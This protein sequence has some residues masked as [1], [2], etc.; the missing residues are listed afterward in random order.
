MI[1]RGRRGLN[2]KLGVREGGA[3]KRLE[4]FDTEQGRNRSSS[5]NLIEM[6]LV[7]KKQTGQNLLI[8]AS[9]VSITH[10]LN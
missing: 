4:R 1:G 6:V 8:V 7:A 10:F 2:A 9:R 3:I 5:F